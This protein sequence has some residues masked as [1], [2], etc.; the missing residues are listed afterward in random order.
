MPQS[1]VTGAMDYKGRMNNNKKKL[2]EMVCFR[3]FP[4]KEL[5]IGAW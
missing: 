4:R 2:E 1:Q 5:I 3:F